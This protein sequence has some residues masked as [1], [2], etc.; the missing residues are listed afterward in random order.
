[1][2]SK[3]LILAIFSLIW[4]LTSCSGGSSSSGG[5]G[6]S[7]PV[8]ATY[9]QTDLEG[10]WNYTAVQVTSREKITGIMTFNSAG[11]LTDF[12]SSNCPGLPISY[13][14]LWY[15]GDGWVKARV[16]S[17]CGD[18]DVYVKFGMQFSDKYTMAGD[19]D[20]HYAFPNKEE[21]YQRYTINLKK[22]G[23]PSPT[24]IPDYSSPMT[25]SN[26]LSKRRP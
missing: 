1:M 6:G 25:V 15:L 20:V 12:N 8:T 18:P 10:T 5:G 21:T 17:F 16:Y 11:L 13:Y 24:P 22:P 2:N 4:L 26:S 14:E 3:G 9:S 23:P 7:I 19:M